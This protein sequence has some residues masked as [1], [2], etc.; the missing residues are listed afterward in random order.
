MRY[1]VGFIGCRPSPPIWR[2]FLVDDRR[3]WLSDEFLP[4][5]PLP[6]IEMLQDP[7]FPLATKLPPYLRIPVAAKANISDVL[8][9][10]AIIG[11]IPLD[12]HHLRWG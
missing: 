12:E 10:L 1:A 6:G 9:Q 7:R 3:T 2:C 4:F 11:G 5:F 8:G